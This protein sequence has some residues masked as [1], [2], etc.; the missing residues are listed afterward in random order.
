MVALVG[1]N[2]DGF[3]IAALLGHCQDPIACSQRGNATP[4][5]T[6]DAGRPLARDKRPLRQELIRAA[7]DQQVDVIDRRGVNLDQDLA[8]TGD[9]CRDFGGAQPLR[10]AEFV[11]NDRTHC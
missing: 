10:P 5:R 7:D 6:D 4:A 3:G 8:R 1:R 2:C 11:D 9:R